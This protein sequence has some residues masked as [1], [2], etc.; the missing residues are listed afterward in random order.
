[1][2]ASH[3]YFECQDLALFLLFLFRRMKEGRPIFRLHTYTL[4]FKEILYIRNPD[5]NFD[6]FQTN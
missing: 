4:Y 2:K 6:Y 1:M 5:F 3:Y